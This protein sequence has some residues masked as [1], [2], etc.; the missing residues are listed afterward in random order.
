MR[1]PFA[2]IGLLFAM[3]SV[4]YSCC[5]GGSGGDAKIVCTVLHH[6]KPIP[7][8]TVYIKYNATE[9]PGLSPS[10]YDA[11]ITASANSNMVTFSGLKCG[12]YYLYGVGYDTSLKLPVTGGIGITI[13]H[14]DREH[15]ESTTVPVTE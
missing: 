4:F 14:S 6:V 12:N 8:A 10:N 11:S 7:G 9:L 3:V 15:T 13:K 1:L 5:K 2:F